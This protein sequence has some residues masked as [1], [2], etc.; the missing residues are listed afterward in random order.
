M[1]RKHK[2]FASAVTPAAKRLHFCFWRRHYN[3]TEAQFLVWPVIIRDWPE[4]MGICMGISLVPT[5][6]EKNSKRIFTPT[7][8]CVARQFLPSQLG[9]CL[10]PSCQYQAGEATPHRGQAH[11]IIPLSCT[12]LHWGGGRFIPCCC[13]ESRW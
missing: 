12:W 7:D 5:H 4:D 13:L 1:Q 2:A 8:P 11:N 10:V 6:D 3:E 9:L